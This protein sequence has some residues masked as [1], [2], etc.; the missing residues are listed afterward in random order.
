MSTDTEYHWDFTASVF[1]GAGVPDDLL[2]MNSEDAVDLQQPE[3]TSEGCFEA[4]VPTHQA[5]I[6][7]ISE[8]VEDTFAGLLSEG[9][10]TD[11]SVLSGET[12]PEYS[13]IDQA[14]VSEFSSAYHA[15][16]EYNPALKWY[17]KLARILK[18]TQFSCDGGSLSLSIT[19]PVYRKILARFINDF[20][21]R[22]VNESPL[23][24][25]VRSIHKA[26]GLAAKNETIGRR[27]GDTSFRNG[28]ENTD[29]HP[30]RAEFE[31]SFD[32]AFEGANPLS[33]DV[34]KEEPA[35]PSVSNG[36]AAS[37][38]ISICDLSNKAVSELFD[39]QKLSMSAIANRMEEDGFSK[40]RVNEISGI[41]KFRRA[42]KAKG[43]PS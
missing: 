35:W 1:E 26:A 21:L 27:Q 32:V 41:I 15:A 29:F 39:A 14:T 3:M 33:N 18:P 8:E 12:P 28:C 7:E 38:D 30:D 11:I 16:L 5:S 22:L 36:K 37:L 43:M 6:E 42:C 40:Q 25:C 24:S 19:A 9:R 4:S 17:G 2:N 10:L 13:S 34:T 23:V 20:P 31:G